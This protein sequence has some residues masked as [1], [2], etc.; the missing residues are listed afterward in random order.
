MRTSN[1][2]IFPISIFILFCFGSARSQTSSNYQIKKSVIAQG[3][4]TANSGNYQITDVIG[5]PGTTG[6]AASENYTV[7]S[8]FVP[9]TTSYSECSLG[10]VNEDAVL[11][12]GDALCA[13]QIYLNGGMPPEGDCNTPCAMAAADVNCD[14]TVTSGD[15]LIIFLAYLQNLTPPL[16]CPPM[17]TAQSVVERTLSTLPVTGSPGEEVTVSAYIS[18]PSGLRALGF[19]INYP[20]NLLSFI[21]VIPADLTQNWQALQGQENTKGVI[22]IGGFHPKAVEST[23]TT[24]IAQIRF[25]VK[26]DVEGAGKIFFSNPTDEIAQA[27][28]ESGDF[29]T[30][31]SGV[32]VLSGS[33]PLE[34]GLEQNYPNPFNLQTEIIYELP[35]TA[36][37]T[38]GIYNTLGQH[39][40]TLIS[41]EQSSARYAISWDGRDEF[42]LEVPSGIYI[43]RL[44]AENYQSVKKMLLLK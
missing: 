31:V 20:A 28:L 36:Q 9:G 8:G 27:K 33:L 37:V 19:D 4:A 15:A 7:R 17:K 16:D 29:S 40:R 11:T 38:L 24:S 14:Q 13:F 43:Y 35:E 1:R 12:P 25:K 23:E 41:R 18:N 32:R 26:E 3:G 5:Q 34:Y 21:E 44:A 30:L 6:D 42:G 10:D 22:S 39:I 2:W